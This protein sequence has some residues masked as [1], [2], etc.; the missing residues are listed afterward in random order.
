MKNISTIHLA[1][2]ICLLLLTGLLIVHPAAAQEED[3]L[4]LRLSRDFGYSSGMGAM[5]GTFSM[6]ASGPDNL[7]KVVF[8]ID[9]LEIG[10]SSAAPFQLRFNTDSY[11]LGAHRMYAIGETQD[12][13]QLRSN[14]IRAEFVSADQGFQAAGQILIPILAVIV[15]AM[16]F[17][18]LLRFLRERNCKTWRQVHL[19]YTARLAAQ[20]VQ[21]AAA[22]FRATFSRRMSF[23]ASWNAVLFV[24][25]GALSG[26][27]QFRS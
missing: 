5:Q 23:L 3:G 17:S 12:G 1:L 19:A 16:L 26:H 15:I 21:N 24:E 20:S 27:G 18:W 13:E 6:K 22:H 4:S 11:S 8:Y 25:G 7:V 10:A 2:R 9:D 14:E